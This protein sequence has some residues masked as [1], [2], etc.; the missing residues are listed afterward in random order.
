MINEKVEKR[1]EFFG[2]HFGA[3]IPFV[4]LLSGIAALAVN[5][6]AGTKPFWACGFMAIM[7][8]MFLAKN[9]K[10]YC[11]AVMKGIADKNGIV[12]IVAWVFASVLGKL[13]VSA[14]MVKGILWLGLSTGLEGSLFTLVV[15]VAAS[16]FSIGTGSSNGTAIALTPV[17]YPAGIYL[18]ADPVWLALAIMS[19]GALGDNL[20]PI[21]DTTIVSAYTQEAKMLDVV[22]SR[23]P[24]A[25]VAA[26]CAM[27]VLFIMGGGGVA[28]SLPELQ[29]QT[30][31][32]CAP[33]LIALAVVVFSALKKRHIIESL[34]YGI[35]TASAIG[36]SIGT[37]TLG[38]LFHIPAKRGMTTGIL[39]DGVNG[40][41]GAVV[42]VIF[43]MAAVRVFVEGGLLDDLMRFFERTIAKTV[44]QAESAIVAVSVVIS[45]VVTANGAALLLV[46]PT[47]VKPLGEKFKLAAA[48]RANLMDCA[49]CSVFYMLPW[50]LAVLVWYNSVST[51]AT[52][53]GMTPP[54]ITI[55]F[56]SPYPWALF[57]VVLF[58]IATGWNRRFAPKEQAEE[59]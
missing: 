53:I 38:D 44:R 29:A 10:Q 24:L 2:G 13:M 12:I 19:G 28:K 47:L 36:I 33:L 42:F 39:Q 59:S 11:Q 14:G 3:L 41:V 6:Q 43:I 50:S 7:A 26:L 49:V 4:V 5:H 40:V 22:K 25:A 18:G 27:V 32:K 57:L 48:R 9:K 30:D 8:G 37:L 51:A 52:S 15:F 17:L 58:S 56:M 31:P 23:F 54:P 46:G 1:L 55:S 20:A 34:T 35:V 21:S 45:A 16:L